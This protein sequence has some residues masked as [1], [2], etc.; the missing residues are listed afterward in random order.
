[1]AYI[2]GTPRDQMQLTLTHLE[3]VVAPDNPVRVI[4]AFVE[5]LDLKQMGFRHTDPHVVGHPSYDP[6][7]K[8]KLY[9]YGYVNRIR[10]S[11]RLEAEAKRNLETKWLLKNLT[12]DFKTIADFRRDHPA[13]LKEVYRQF[14]KLLDDLGLIGKETVAIDGT[15]MKASNAKK[16]NHNAKSLA[17][18]RKYHDKK[19]NE[20]LKDLDQNDEQEDAQP[21]KSAEE[22]KDIVKKLKERRAKIEE[23]EH[24]MKETGQ[25]EISTTDPDA[26]LMN[27]GKNALE[28]CYNVQTAVDDKHNLVVDY[29]ITNQAS[30][31]G[32]LAPMASRMKKL[33]GKRYVLLADKGY[34][35]AS[36]L[37]ECAK[38][39]ITTYVAKQAHASPTG[40]PDY[41]R[42]NFTYNRE[43]NTYTCP[44][45]QEL[46]QG[47]K[48]SEKGRLVGWDYKNLK[49]CRAC[50]DR[51]QC[52]KSK[53]GRTIHRHADQDFLD[54]IDRATQE[55]KH[56]YRKR[57]MMVE[58]PY[59]TIKGAW[60]ADYFLVRGLKAVGGEAAL[61]FTAYNLVR[62]VNILGVTKLLELLKAKRVHLALG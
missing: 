7:D 41:A 62:V 59:G 28:V 48:R 57:Q 31:Q 55:N 16:N 15:K 56:I 18:K 26:R 12:P 24:T 4:D 17:R 36:D 32:Q 44:A 9:L 1:M 13:Q 45:G 53:Q 47:R 40:N 33:F 60:G 61:L 51:S 54:Q 14:V 34:Y 49:A 52:T 29:R 43:T 35:Q 30:D 42:E 20:Y 19:I 2:K 6:K 22:I 46:H 8:L 58:H 25:T 50:E 23:L 39:D 10:S 3:D 38:E 37:K 5:S 11:R 27:N 21:R